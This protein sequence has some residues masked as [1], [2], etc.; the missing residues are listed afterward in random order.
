MQIDTYSSEKTYVLRVSVVDG[1]NVEYNASKEIESTETFF[2]L[3]LTPNAFKDGNMQPLES[4][5]SVK[6]LTVLT[7]GVI[8]GKIMFI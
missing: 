3:L 7:S 2:S 6:S 1:N 4:W 8:V 5:E